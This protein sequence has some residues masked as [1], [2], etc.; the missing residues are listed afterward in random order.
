MDD[1]FKTQKNITVSHQQNLIAWLGPV[2]GALAG[3][4]L[5]A[6]FYFLSNAVRSEILHLALN[7]PGFLIYLTIGSVYT[8]DVDVLDQQIILFGI[9]SIPYAVLGALFGSKNKGLIIM[10]IVLFIIYSLVSATI[11]FGL[12]L[13]FAADY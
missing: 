6:L 4:T 3:I 5:F 12:Y 11:G 10:G 1:P 7:A 2:I 13:I 8:S 9:S